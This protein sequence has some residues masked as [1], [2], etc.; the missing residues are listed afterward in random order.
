MSRGGRGIHNGEHLEKIVRTL[1][2]DGSGG[3][4]AKGGELRIADTLFFHEHVICLQRIVVCQGRTNNKRSEK[5]IPAATNG[6][7]P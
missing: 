4:K 7:N 6:D 1:A 3:G 2:S 5:V